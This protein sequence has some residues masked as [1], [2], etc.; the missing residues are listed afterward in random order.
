MQQHVVERERSGAPTATVRVSASW[1]AR[2]ADDVGVVRRH[3]VVWGLCVPRGPWAQCSSFHSPLSVVVRVLVRLRSVPCTP[4]HAHVTIAPRVAAL[5]SGLHV[6][7]SV[8]VTA[9]VNATRVD[10]VTSLPRPPQEPSLRPV[11]HRPVLHSVPTLPA[12]PR[13]T[14]VTH[15]PTVPELR[16]LPYSP[17][18][19]QLPIVP[20]PHESP[21]SPYEPNAPHPPQS[22]PTTTRRSTPSSRRSYTTQPHPPR[23]P[24]NLDVVSPPDAPRRCVH[25]TTP[26]PPRTRSPPA[27]SH[28]V[29]L[30]EQGTTVVACTPAVPNAP[31]PFSDSTAPALDRPG[32]TAHVGVA[33]NQKSDRIPLGAGQ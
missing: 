19:A 10:H 5:P 9:A 20:H 29:R 12:T 23:P 28:R 14:T 15:A 25:A 2:T 8:L 4:D 16:E 26:P 18:A 31:E 22:P 17:R 32:A 11:P 13:T 3:A 1:T 21:H 24:V 30:N 27:A 33:R 6:P 7:I